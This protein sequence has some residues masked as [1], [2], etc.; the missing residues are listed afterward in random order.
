[1]LYP[2]RLIFIR[3]FTRFSQCKKNQSIKQIKAKGEAT[4]LIKLATASPTPHWRWLLEISVYSIMLTSISMSQ[5]KERRIVSCVNQPVSEQARV[6]AQE[7]SP[8]P[9]KRTLFHAGYCRYSEVLIVQIGDFDLWLPAWDVWLFSPTHNQCQVDSGTLAEFLNQFLMKSG[10]IQQTSG[11]SVG[12]SMAS[13]PTSYKF[14]DSVMAVLQ[15]HSD[16]SGRRQSSFA[17]LSRFIE[18][19]KTRHCL[20]QNVNP[21]DKLFTLFLPTCLLSC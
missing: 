2:E 5:V 9:N 19:H 8:N 11:A 1:M 6:L 21:K 18:F 7:N 17:A 15:F 4:H 12:V 13:K 16:K 14:V 20:L 3:N 10:E